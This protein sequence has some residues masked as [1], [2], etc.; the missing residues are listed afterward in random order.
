M[1][2][3]EGEE[4]EE[5]KR[6]KKKTKRKRKKRKKNKGATTLPALCPQYETECFELTVICE[7]G[8]FV[9][10]IPFWVRSWR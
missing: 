8:Y 4:V 9:S 1:A 6:K 5:E 3:E 10:L 2:V 7:Y